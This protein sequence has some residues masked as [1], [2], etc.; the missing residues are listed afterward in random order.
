MSFPSNEP[1]T[2]LLIARL[3]YDKGIQEYI[4][5]IKLLRE[6]QINAKF[7]LLGA[8]DPAH[9]RGIPSKLIDHWADTGVVEYHGTTDDVRDYINRADCIVLPSYREGTPRT[10]LEAASLAKPIVTTDVPGCQHVVEH[11]RNGF[12]CAPKSARDLADKMAD[13]CMLTEQ[14]RRDMGTYGRIKIENEY[15]EHMVIEKYLEAIH[16]IEPQIHV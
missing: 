3:I 1:F 8:K 12:L 4:D 2:F 7:Q 16:S 11:G 9:K 13:M 15:D 5:A 6:S 14:T 10:L